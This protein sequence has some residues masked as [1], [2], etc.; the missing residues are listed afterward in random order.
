MDYRDKITAKKKN[1]SKLFQNVNLT[2]GSPE[3]K[4]E[5]LKEIKPDEL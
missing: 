2:S 5:N 3:I 4:P 1:N